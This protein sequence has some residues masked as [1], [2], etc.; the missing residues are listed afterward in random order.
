[1]ATTNQQK[2]DP[3]PQTLG[4]GPQTLKNFRLERLAGDPQGPALRGARDR[5]DLVGSNDLTQLLLGADR[6]SSEL[7]GTFRRA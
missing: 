1:L 4:T 2:K 7:S 3:T 6:D 5:W